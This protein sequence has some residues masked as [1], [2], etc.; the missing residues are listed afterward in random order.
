ME[1]W[2]IRKNDIIADGVVRMTYSQTL[3]PKECIVNQGLSNR[4]LLM[5]NHSDEA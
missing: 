1:K 2:L 3:H 4:S 5:K